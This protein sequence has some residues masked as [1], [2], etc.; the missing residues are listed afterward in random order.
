MEDYYYK[1]FRPLSSVPSLLK[2]EVEVCCE[3]AFGCHSF[4][5]GS[6]KGYFYLQSTTKQSETTLGNIKSG[7]EL[8]TSKKKKDVAGPEI[9][10][11]F[12]RDLIS[13]SRSRL[14]KSGN[15]NFW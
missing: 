12:S 15:C 7:L 2:V 4:K 1:L 9:R 6:S 5:E 10:R 11:R 13:H 8:A 14:E 3:M